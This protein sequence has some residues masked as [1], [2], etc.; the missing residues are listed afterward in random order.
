MRRKEQASSPARW[1]EMVNELL[2]D[3]AIAAHYQI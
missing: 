3:P 1:A 2:G